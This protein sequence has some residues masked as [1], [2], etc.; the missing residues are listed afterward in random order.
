MATLAVLL[1]ACGGGAA[2]PVPSPATNPSALTSIAAGTGNAGAGVAAAPSIAAT[3]AVTSAGAPVASRSPEAS[4]PPSAA[5]VS[6]PPTVPL[7]PQPAA[8]RIGPLTFISQTLNNCGPASVAEVL[9]YYGIKRTQAQVASVLRPTLPDYGMSLYGVPFYAESVGLRGVGGVNGTDELIKAFVANDLPVIVADL[10]SRRETI[11]HFRPI[12]GYDDAA[13]YFIGSD[14]YMGPN[15]RIAYADFDDLWKISTN[16]WVLI[17][18]PAKQAVVD[19]ILSRYWDRTTASTA[20]LEKAV[21]R[22]DQQPR[23]PWT[24]LEMADLQMDLGNTADARTNIRKG[25]DLG[26]PYEGR[27]LDMKLQ[28]LTAPAGAAAGR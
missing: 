18:P 11:R 5:P 17:Y 28:R 10:I 21:Q 7:N 24:W 9:D 22:M 23:L 6:A 19:G 2:L 4:A 1:S 20:A 14:P 13:G 25:I 27:W 3:P 15:H 12:D 8:K 26:L 16:R